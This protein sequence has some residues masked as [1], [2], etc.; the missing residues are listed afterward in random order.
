MKKKFLIF[1]LTFTLVVLFSMSASAYTKSLNGNGYVVSPM[2]TYI[3]SASAS[4]SISKDEATVETYVTGNSEVTSISAIVNLQ[5]YKNNKWT[6]I[7]SWYESSSTRIL[8]SVNTYVVSRGYSYRVS[9][10]VIAYSGQ[11]SETITVVS[12]SNNY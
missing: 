9:S 5:Q 4:I 2:F 8:D 12:S 7:K 1:L 3:S 11:N 10:T 6:T